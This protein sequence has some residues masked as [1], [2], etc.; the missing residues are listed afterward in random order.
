ME[1]EKGNGYSIGIRN[2]N[3]WRAVCWKLKKIR[4]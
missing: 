4:N 2:G 1:T 3:E